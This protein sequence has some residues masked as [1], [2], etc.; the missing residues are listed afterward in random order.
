MVRAD[1]GRTTPRLIRRNDCMLSVATYVCALDALLLQC[2]QIP[3]SS[4]Y[5]FVEREVPRTHGK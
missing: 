4:G 2:A 1:V 3:S 5:I